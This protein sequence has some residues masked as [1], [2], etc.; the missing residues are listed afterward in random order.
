VKYSS[1]HLNYS[2][3][4][5]IKFDHLIAEMTQSASVEDYFPSKKYKHL[6]KF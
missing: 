3:A 1:K 6:K 4:I 5:I 2:F